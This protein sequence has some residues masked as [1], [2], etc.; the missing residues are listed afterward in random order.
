[1]RTENY[2]ADYSHLEHDEYGNIIT[3]EEALSF[4]VEYMVD[5]IFVNINNTPILSVCIYFLLFNAK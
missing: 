4:P 5:T 2:R 3:L 1:M